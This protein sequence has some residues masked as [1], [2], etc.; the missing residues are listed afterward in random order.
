MKS[1]INEQEL[2]LL[3]YLH[4]Q[5]QGFGKEFQQPADAIMAAL[6]LTADQLRKA[7]SYLQEHGLAGVVV[8]PVVTF[9]QEGQVEVESLWLTGLG[10]DYLREL[11][12]APGVGSKLTVAAISEMWGM[13]KGVIVAAAAKILSEIMVRP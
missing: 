12:A 1:N 3:T 9:D 7:G 6:N 5:A 2:T 4:E 8:T 11:E 13:G 10:E